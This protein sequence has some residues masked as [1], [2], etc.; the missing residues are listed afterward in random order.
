M[1]FKKKKKRKSGVKK[2]QRF[3]LKEFFTVPIIILSPSLLF[4]IVLIHLIAIGYLPIFNRFLSFRYYL[5]KE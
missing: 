1:F 4:K 5:P 2:K 3:N